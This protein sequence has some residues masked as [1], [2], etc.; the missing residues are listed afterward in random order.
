MVG[1]MVKKMADLTVVLMVAMKV[2]E[3]EKSMVVQWVG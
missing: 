1:E 2:G 3:M